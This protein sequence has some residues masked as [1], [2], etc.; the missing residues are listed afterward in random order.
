MDNLRRQADEQ[1]VT[2]RSQEDELSSKKQELEGLKQEE[3]R[4]EQKQKES[5]DKL[6]DLTKNL[7]DTQL[8]ISQAKAKITQLQEQ[9][10]QM[11]DAITV[12]DTAI[13]SGDPSC[14][15][16]T[17]LDIEPEFRNP[18][19]R[20]LATLEQVCLPL[21]LL[22]GKRGKLTQFTLWFYL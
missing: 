17:S 19:Y 14:V 5:R 2:L 16:D 10:R 20:K 1:E 3:S 4:L 12:C 15:G 8:Q 22:P 13:E 7:R 9:H 11:N 6:D 18:E 21:F